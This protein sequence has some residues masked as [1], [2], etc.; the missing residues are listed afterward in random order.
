[1]KATTLVAGLVLAC[2]AALSAA[3]PA[4]STNAAGPHVFEKWCA[5]CHAA[6]PGH[7]GTIALS[8]KYQGRLP[9]ALLERT[10]LTPQTVSYFVR[11]GVSV[12]PFFRK[13]EISDVELAALAQF[14]SSGGSEG[15]RVQ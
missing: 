14:L 15:R 8:A 2:A 4:S 5:P 9:G 3:A 10:D 7:P 6:G 12:M 11:H 13:T 1:M